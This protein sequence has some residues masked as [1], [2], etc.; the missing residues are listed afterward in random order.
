MIEGQEF[1]RGEKRK[2]EGKQSSSYTM[3]SSGSWEEQPERHDVKMLEEQR[4]TLLC[5]VATAYRYEQEQAGGGKGA[6]RE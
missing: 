1:K 5:L 4:V 3:L 2:G 6:Q